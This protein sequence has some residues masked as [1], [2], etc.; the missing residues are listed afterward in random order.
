MNNCG[1]TSF[2]PAELELWGGYGIP[3]FW[4]DIND[5][6][7]K[8]IF[9]VC[10]KEGKSIRQIADEIGVAP[11]YFEQKLD[12][13][14]KEKFLKES[15]KG[16]YLTDFC[17]YPKKVWSGFYT[18]LSHIY[19]QIGMEITEAVLSQEKAV[20][21]LDFYGN[22]FPMKKL[23]WILYCEAGAVMSRTMLEIYNG[24]W[25]GKIPDNNGKSYRIAGMVSYPDEKVDGDAPKLNTVA[26][27]NFHRHFKTSC[28]DHIE[29]AN[30]FETEPFG[31]RDNIINESNADLF[32]RIFDDPNLLLTSNEE[33]AAANLIRRDYLHKKDG[34]LYLSVPV[35]SYDCKAKLH[36]ILSDATASLAL[37]YVGVVAQAGERI[38]MPWVRKD[39]IEEFAHWSME[40]AFFPIGYIY[41]YG[42]NSTPPTLEIPDDYANSSD[43]VCILYK[44]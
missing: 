16:T 28:Y 36:R 11:V 40:N 12:F 33:E 43:A 22:A 39:L 31:E 9:A 19:D 38:L 2:A 15:S 23:L 37:K 41:Y 4:A 30:L 21:A 18:E 44:K 13:L 27:S 6:M 20:R 3:D 24:K 29:H 25:K 42:M 7:T 14:L 17:I 10:S 35:M 5:I 32:M 8:Q 34:G 1:R 26:W